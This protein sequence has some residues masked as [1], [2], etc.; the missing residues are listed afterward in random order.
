MTAEAAKYFSKSNKDIV[1]DPRRRVQFL[2][3][4]SLIFDLVSGGGLPRGR[5]TEVFGMEHSGKS[6]L[7]WA[8]LA[9]VQ[10]SGGVGVLVDYEGAF[11]PDFARACYG[12]VVDNKTFA[13]F[14]PDNI[15][16]GDELFMKYISRL[17]QLDM[18]VYDSVDA[19]KPKGLI[20][21]ALAD[22]RR[23][24][25]HAQAMS[26]YVA[27]QRAFA[28]QR[29]IVIGFVNQMRT[30]IVTGQAA[31]QNVGTGAGYNVME[32]Y[33]TTGGLALRYYASL[34]MK[35][36]YGGQIKDEVALSEIT[37]V[38]E[39][40][41]VGNQI[42]M[43]NIKNKVGVPFRRANATFLFPAPDQTPGWANDVDLMELLKKR[44]RIQQISSKFVYR[45]LNI[46][47]WI[48]LTGKVASE[49]LFLSKPELQAD[50]QA[51]FKQI[52]SGPRAQDQVTVSTEAAI[53]GVDFSPNEASEP[54]SNDL[55]DLIGV[56]LPPADDDT[57]VD[58]RDDEIVSPASEVSL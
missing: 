14:Q 45:G 39:V 48:S 1:Y 47:E 7:Y 18:L 31:D 38:Q 13:L 4:G 46:P 35:L 16:E 32:K 10:R 5:L 26:R 8:A 43:I 57:Q 34:R 52:I 25:A 56:A 40:Q 30:N 24:G 3:S 53:A 36:E 23:V 9:A 2:T 37:G 6:S 28:R 17:A 54:T 55:T 22:E 27:K 12:L 44:G 19:M 49:K 33:T 41:R 58:M 15:E 42:K 11:D 20:E 50:A 29:G 21:G 51:L